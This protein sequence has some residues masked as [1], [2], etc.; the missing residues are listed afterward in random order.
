MSEYVK[1]AISFVIKILNNNN[2]STAEGLYEIYE[3]QNGNKK[4]ITEHIKSIRNIMNKA[5]E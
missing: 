2:E 5:L 4:I 3:I 1:I